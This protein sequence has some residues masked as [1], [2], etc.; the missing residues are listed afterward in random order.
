MPEEVAYYSGTISKLIDAMSVG[1]EFNR[2]AAI[3]QKMI[4]YLSF[5][6]AKG[7]AGQERALVTAAFAANRIE[8]AQ[9]RVILADKD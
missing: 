6:R 5:V 1:I 9:Y 2:D 4:A 3:S 8:P 7:N